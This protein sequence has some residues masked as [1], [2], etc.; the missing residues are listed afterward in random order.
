MSGNPRRIRLDDLPTE[1]LVLIL[2]SGS[3]K[4]ALSFQQVNRR[5]RDVC[6][7]VH[8]FKAIAT[9]RNGLG[10]PAWSPPLSPTASK[11]LWSQYA[12]ADEV[13]SDQ[14]QHLKL[15]AL[16]YRFITWMPLLLAAQHPIL[17]ESGVFPNTIFDDIT[18][19]HGTSIDQCISAYAL[20]FSFLLKILSDN[21]PNVTFELEDEK[22][23]EMLAPTD[24]FL[25][26]VIETPLTDAIYSPLQLGTY[27]PILS[28][29]IAIIP[30]S[31]PFCK[32]WDPH[33]TP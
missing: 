30:Q 6:N 31:A 1:I 2:T 14:G 28:I 12:L 20:A 7:D 13:A 18:W 3:C 27:S 4:T 33:S 25:K 23:D 21:N 26:G 16:R 5:C 10:G 8:V 17:G 9:N 22:E 15:G 32:A 11:I 24:H 19:Y 29:F